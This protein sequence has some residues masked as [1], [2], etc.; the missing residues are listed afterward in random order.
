MKICCKHNNQ[1]VFLPVGLGRVS[2]ILIGGQYRGTKVSRYRYRGTFF[3]TGT[4]AT[5]VVPVPRY[6][7]IFWRYLYFSFVLFLS[8][9]FKKVIKNLKRCKNACE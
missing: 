2:L 6:F 9:D 3:G 7:A 5:F 4:V 1:S 8:V